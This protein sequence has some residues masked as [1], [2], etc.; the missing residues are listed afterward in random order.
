MGSFPLAPP[1]PERSNTPPQEGTPVF[2]SESYVLIA[3]MRRE[4]WYRR[5]YRA[6]MWQ[7]QRNQWHEMGF[8][9]ETR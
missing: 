5:I 1:I 6:V 9:D 8:V 4:R 2:D 7:L 3:P